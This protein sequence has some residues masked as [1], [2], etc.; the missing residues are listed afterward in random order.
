[1][2]YK[3]QANVIG[4]SSSWKERCLEILGRYLANIL[5]WKD[6][7]C[8]P[9]CLDLYKI[10]LQIHLS[11]QLT[12]VLHFCNSIQ[13]LG[14]HLRKSNGCD[15]NWR[16]KRRPLDVTSKVSQWVKQSPLSVVSVTL[17]TSTTRSYLIR[18]FQILHV[19]G[20]DRD[21]ML[22]CIRCEVATFL[23]LMG[24]EFIKPM[25]HYF[26]NCSSYFKLSFRLN[27][28]RIGSSIHLYPKFN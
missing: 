1:M 17:P 15:S 16:V 27:I 25:W 13:I 20:Y 8:E 10:Y 21:F 12:R 3:I 5:F 18:K 6:M 9:F 22:F 7:S 2:F 24:F 11:R 26:G 23:P 14:P 4:S 28:N 19:F